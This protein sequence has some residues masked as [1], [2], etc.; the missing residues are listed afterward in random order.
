MDAYDAEN[1]SNSEAATE[2]QATLDED[3]ELM[4]T[5]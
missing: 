4:V 3:S 2:F 5:D 1:A